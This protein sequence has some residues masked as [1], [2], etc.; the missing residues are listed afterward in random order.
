MR[1]PHK[2]AAQEMVRTNG[3]KAANVKIGFRRNCCFRNRRQ[4]PFPKVD[5]ISSHHHASLN[6]TR[7]RLLRNSTCLKPSVSSESAWSEGVT[8]HVRISGRAKYLRMR[9]QN[10]RRTYSLFISCNASYVRRVSLKPKFN[11]HAMRLYYDN[12]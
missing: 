7:F 10:H 12:M 6:P 3:K 1:Q 5:L 9:L 2:Q 11:S 8:L 4:S